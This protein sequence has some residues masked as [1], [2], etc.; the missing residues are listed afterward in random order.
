MV[1]M[2]VMVTGCKQGKDKDTSIIINSF[3][4]SYFELQGSVD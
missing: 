1:M 2:E 4:E 3:K